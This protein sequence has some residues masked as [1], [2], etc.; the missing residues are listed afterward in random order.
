M[1]SSDT[2]LSYIIQK[3]KLPHSSDDDDGDDGQTSFIVII[4]FFLP[5]DA[6]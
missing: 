4:F 5:R 6:L 1:N 2:I 3:I